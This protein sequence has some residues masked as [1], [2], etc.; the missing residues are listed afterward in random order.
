[1]NFKSVCIIAHF[2][3]VLQYLRVLC[4]SGVVQMSGLFTVL[5]YKKGLT[6]VRSCRAS[7][8]AFF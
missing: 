6:T 1:M 8:M 7:K 3:I 5:F 2:T 4:E